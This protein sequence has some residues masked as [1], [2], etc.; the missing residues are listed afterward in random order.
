LGKCP[1]FGKGARTECW[2]ECSWRD[3]CNSGYE[4]AFHTNL[5]NEVC[6]KNLYGKSFKEW[7]VR[8]EKSI[9]QPFQTVE[10]KKR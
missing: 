9:P 6:F 2:S 7:N 8:I 5:V 10:V 4:H 1:N 3:A